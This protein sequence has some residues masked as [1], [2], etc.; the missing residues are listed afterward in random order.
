MGTYKRSPIQQHTSAIVEGFVGEEGALENIHSVVKGKL[1]ELFVSN[2]L[3]KLLVSQFGIGI[4]SA[5]IN[6]RGEQSS[7]IDIIIY[8]KRILPPFIGEQVGAF[9][10]ESVLATIEVKG[11]ICRDTIKE[12]SKKATELYEGIYDPASSIY[13]DLDS[14]KPLYGLVGFHDKGIYQWMV[15]KVK[16]KCREDILQWMA[17]NARPLLG[18]C[19]LNKFS[20]VDVTHPKAPY[21]SLKLYDKNN[22]ETKAFIAVLLDNIRTRSQVR[23]LSLVGEKHKDWLS[24]Y[25]RDQT[26]I[27]RHFEKQ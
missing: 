19:L 6:Q 22:E 26:G 3:S 23:Y 2:F 24:I 14:F 16:S 7:E 11:P 17:D 4:G 25:T 13:Q 8:D 18:V 1:R 10:A 12:F 21:G 15:D 9:P 27:R 20:W 5:I